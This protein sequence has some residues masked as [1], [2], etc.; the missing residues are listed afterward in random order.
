ML[1]AG[2]PTSKPTPN[3]QPVQSEL[4]HE[5]DEAPVPQPC[6]YIDSTTSLPSPVPTQP[7]TV[8]PP[9]ATPSQ[10][11]H[12]HAQEPITTRIDR[13]FDM[14]ALF[15]AARLDESVTEDAWNDLVLP[16][17]DDDLCVLERLVPRYVWPGE[18]AALWPN[19]VA[20][21]RWWRAR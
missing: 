21:V 4:G 20:L 7:E 12:E 8:A 15:N 18:I 14:L 1:C 17:Q 2:T 6:I 3:H 5:N 10:R 13:L 16:Y 19:L 9:P 11:E